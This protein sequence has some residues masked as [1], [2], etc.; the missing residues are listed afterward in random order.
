[1]VMMASRFQWEN[2]EAGERMAVLMEA[3]AWDLCAGFR[4][5]I[6]QLEDSSLLGGGPSGRNISS[7]L[8][9]NS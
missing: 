5:R 3:A 7:S 6:K 9:T 8:S 1:M 4:W 2:Q